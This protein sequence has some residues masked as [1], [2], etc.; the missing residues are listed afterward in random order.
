MTKFNKNV[1]EAKY[2]SALTFE[3]SKYTIFR[4]TGNEITKDIR[5][6]QNKKTFFFEGPLKLLFP[7][8]L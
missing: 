7:R 8:N 3:K 1:L 6:F 5:G 2:V 4:N